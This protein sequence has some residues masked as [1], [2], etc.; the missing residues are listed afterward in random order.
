MKAKSYQK[1][2]LTNQY[3][4]IFLVERTCLKWNESLQSNDS[5]SVIT[6]SK[7]KEY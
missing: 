4:F 2:I 7:G 6:K 3:T 5:F 1:L